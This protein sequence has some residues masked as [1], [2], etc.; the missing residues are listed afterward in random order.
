MRLSDLSSPD[1]AESGTFENAALPMIRADDERACLRHA[2]V[3]RRRR[4][5]DMLLLLP[6]C[7]ICDNIEMFDVCL[8]F[9]LYFI[10]FTLESLRIR[11]YVAILLEKVISR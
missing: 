1:N 4:V 7:A 5:E 10:D 11:K 3:W 9:L 8:L 2:T 6:F